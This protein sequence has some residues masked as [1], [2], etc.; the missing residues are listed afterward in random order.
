MLDEMWASALAVQLRSRGLD[1][2]A[3][4]DRPDLRG[5]P[6]DVVF[7]VAQEEERTI[8]TENVRDFRMLA[9]DALRSGHSHFGLVY[10]TNRTFPRHDP[11]TAGR[12]VIALV[13]LERDGVASNNLEHWLAQ[14][15]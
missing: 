9:D 6:D 11:R 3:V 4:L 1:A 15:L 8:V 14:P 5:K 12:L 13:T 10:T 2:I 7:A